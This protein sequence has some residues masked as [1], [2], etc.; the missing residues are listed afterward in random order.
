MSSRSTS[1][2][3]DQVDVVSPPLVLYLW[4][5]GLTFGDEVQYVW[6]RKATL[7]TVLFMLNR[8]LNLMITIFELLEQA[9]FQSIKVRRPLFHP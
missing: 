3:I 8:Y 2:S 5:F 1:A 7:A 9:P 4:D 6:G